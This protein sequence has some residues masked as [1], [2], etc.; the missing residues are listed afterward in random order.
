MPIP[1]TASPHSH[2]IYSKPLRGTQI[3]LLALQP[4]DKD[5]RLVCHLRIVDV[6]D[7][8][9]SY[10]AISYVGGSQD[11]PATIHCRDGAGYGHVQLPIPQN[12][13]DALEA[14][15][16]PQAERLLWIDSVCISQASVEEKSAQVA[17]MGLIFSN[18][19]AVLICLGSDSD[20]RPTGAG[21]LFDRMSNWC[22]DATPMM[23]RDMYRG[24]SEPP[25]YT[26]DEIETLLN[27]FECEWVWR[28]LC[29]QELVLA[30]KAWVQWA[31][32]K[33]T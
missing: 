16:E 5:D 28:L 30:K 33:M 18:A 19:T 4:R 20:F 27:V 12:A 25:Y 6:A 23:I 11:K 13:A 15:R 8:N 17:M 29:V 21:E 7:E 2:T 32:A 1:S 3:R 22:R 26:D 31:A 14:F 10:E 9:L 24:S